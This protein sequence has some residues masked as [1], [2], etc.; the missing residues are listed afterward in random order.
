MQATALSVPLRGLG[1]KWKVSPYLPIMT[2][3][4]TSVNRL[5]LRLVLESTRKLEYT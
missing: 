4:L 2:D 5:R 1:K 3:I